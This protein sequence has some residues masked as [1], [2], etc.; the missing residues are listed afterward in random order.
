[1]LRVDE[2][3]EAPHLFKF[4]RSTVEGCRVGRT[5]EERWMEA[6]DLAA[7]FFR[8]GRR[9]SHDEEEEEST[10]KKTK[11]RKSVV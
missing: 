9:R 7:R 5:L 3:Y 10:K 1:M 8:F 6:R 11:D 2:V 4:S